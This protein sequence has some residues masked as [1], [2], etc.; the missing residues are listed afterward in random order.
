M[1]V[2]A[3]FIAPGPATQTFEAK[4]AD[5]VDLQTRANAWLAAQDISRALMS[6]E[7]AGCGDGINYQ[8]TLVSGPPYDNPPNFGIFAITIGEQPFAAALCQVRL[9]HGQS[10]AALAQNFGTAWATVQAIDVVK[11][12]ELAGSSQGLNHMGM[13]VILPGQM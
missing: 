6:A 13:M 2:F 9:W 7:L 10:Q 1:S 11:S 8:L 12:L 4:S 3:Y 5:P